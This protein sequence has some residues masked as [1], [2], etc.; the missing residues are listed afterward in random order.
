MVNSV[1][2]QG[3]DRLGS[4]L[5]VEAIASDD[6]LVEAVSARPCGGDVLAVQWHPEWD[7][8]GCAP[9]RAFFDLFHRALRDRPA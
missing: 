4:G 2:E 9:S 3:V 7:V 8:A 1:H 6:G 5:T